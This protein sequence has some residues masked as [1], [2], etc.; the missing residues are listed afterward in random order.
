MRT[1][2]GTVEQ[3]Y[4]ASCRPRNGALDKGTDK[5]NREAL[6]ALLQTHTELLLM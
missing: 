1:K 2:E 3:T 6:F 5:R 4:R